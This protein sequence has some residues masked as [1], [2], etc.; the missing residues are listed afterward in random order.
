[1]LFNYEFLVHT[2]KVKC[3]ITN[4][5]WHFIIVP[6]DANDSERWHLKSEQDSMM[7][8]L[9]F[10]WPSWLYLASRTNY[11]CLAKQIRAE[12]ILFVQRGW[13]YLFNWADDIC[14]A[15]MMIFVK[16]R[17]WYLAELIED[18]EQVDLPSAAAVIHLLW[19]IWY[20][21]YI[22]CDTSAALNSLR[23]SADR[24]ESSVNRWLAIGDGR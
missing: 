10:V 1:M 21:W 14:S 19:Y 8:L 24:I 20:I 15:E 7:R 2:H 18:Q 23:R 22:W 4:I 9:L 11:I 17:W 5:G 12:L 6:I 13:W 3:A 16:S